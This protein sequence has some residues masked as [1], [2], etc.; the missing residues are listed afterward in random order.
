M[1]TAAELLD[2]VNLAISKCLTS[3]G[4]SIRSRNQQM[5][6]LDDLRKFRAELIAEVDEANT[7]GGTMGSV[8]RVDRPY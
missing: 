3:Q 7:N 1:A 5:A 8:C 2:E 6:R 4:Y